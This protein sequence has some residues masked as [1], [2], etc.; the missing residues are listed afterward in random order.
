V[1]QLVEEA[2][3]RVVR[4]VREGWVVV[5]GGATR[6]APPQ[7]WLLG[8]V[9]PQDSDISRRRTAV[10]MNKTNNSGIR[11]DALPRGRAGDESDESSKAPA[12]EL[13]PA[14]AG[15]GV[16]GEEVR[17]L[18]V[19]RHDPL[20]AQLE[21]LRRKL[22]RVL[23]IVHRR[24][25]P[26]AEHVVKMVKETGARFLV[27]VLP[28]TMIAR[29]AELAPEN[30]FTLLYSR[31]RVVADAEKSDRDALQKVFELY[32]EKP[33]ARTIVEYPDRLR[34]LEFERFEVLKRVEVV[35]EPW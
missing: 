30:G 26:N 13:G 10:M 35:T 4:K 12:A 29:L 1:E 18:W 16:S 34:L 2:V 15:E 25:V 3:E 32:R 21:A 19:S 20:P 5:S 6:S 9:F 33:D 24:A 11:A 7:L 27:A 28:L 14:A 8:A 23:V 17:V 22:G 31:M